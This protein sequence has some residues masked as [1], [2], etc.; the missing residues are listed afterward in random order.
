M[1]GPSP[2]TTLKGQSSSG[3]ARAG[4]ASTL[5]P[6]ARTG[7]GVSRTAGLVLVDTSPWAETTQGRRNRT[8]LAEKIAPRRNGSIRGGKC[9]SKRF[10]PRLR[11]RWPTTFS[12]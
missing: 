12:G 9:F 1:A 4:A 7:S 6:A 10:R 11:R 3:V 2:T 5:R 8:E